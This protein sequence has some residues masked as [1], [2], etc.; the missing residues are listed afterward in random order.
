[1]PENKGKLI[2]VRTTYIPIL[3]NTEFNSCAG[4]LHCLRDGG[5]PQVM[6]SLLESLTNIFGCRKGL[7]FHQFKQISSSL[8]REFFFMQ[9]NQL[10]YECYVRVVTGWLSDC[11]CKFWGAI[12]VICPV[13]RVEERSWKHAACSC[14][15]ILS[16]IS[17]N[18]CQWALVQSCV[19]M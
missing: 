5:M 10:K 15:L 18:E 14:G 19:S 11:S 8:N 7:R 9:V 12:L 13:S 17:H 2:V 16:D 6:T 4:N 1:M 3:K